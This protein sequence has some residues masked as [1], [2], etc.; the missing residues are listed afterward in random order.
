MKTH[1]IRFLTTLL[2]AV[3]LILPVTALFSSCGARSTAK[4]E[5]ALKDA[6]LRYSDYF[7]LYY[8]TVTVTT[9][10]VKGRFYD[11]KY[12][13]NPEG[14]MPTLYLSDGTGIEGK[15]EFNAAITKVDLRKGDTVEYGWSFDIPKDFTEGRYTVRVEWQG[16]EQIFEDVSFTK[17]K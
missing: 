2:A 8:A 11:P 14:G 10:C 6:E 9:T 12:P 15:A 5:F 1:R 13:H 7:G 3:L 17:A 16:S 4:F